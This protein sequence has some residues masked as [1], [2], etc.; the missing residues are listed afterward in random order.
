MCINHNLLENNLQK[1]NLSPAKVHL[2]S[3]A[4]TYK[5]VR[6][7]KS[8]NEPEHPK[9][10]V[11]PYVNTENQESELEGAH[12]RPFHTNRRPIKRVPGGDSDQSGLSAA[13]TRFGRG[14]E[15]LSFQVGLV[16]IYIPFLSFHFY[17][18]FK[19]ENRKAVEEKLK[20]SQGKFHTHSSVS[21]C[22]SRQISKTG[23]TKTANLLLAS[24]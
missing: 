19:E 12:G 15:K 21:F 2:A 20:Y 7:I 17:L 13:S 9:T 4:T 22:L 24:F 5:P 8:M 14:E 18:C 3:L 11:E 10:T 23:S 1:Y 6:I 16:Y